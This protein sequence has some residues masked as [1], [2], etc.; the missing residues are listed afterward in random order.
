MIGH[1]VVYTSG[2]ILVVSSAKLVAQGNL[3]IEQAKGW[4]KYEV[5]WAIVIGVMNADDQMSVRECLI[6]DG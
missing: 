6:N 2:D 5:V 1:S 3:F 4:A